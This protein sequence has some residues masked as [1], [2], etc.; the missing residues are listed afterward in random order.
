LGEKTFAVL[1]LAATSAI[2]AVLY[3]RSFIVDAGEWRATLFSTSLL[4]GLGK[5]EC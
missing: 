2:L 3:V 1:M 5:S 4:C